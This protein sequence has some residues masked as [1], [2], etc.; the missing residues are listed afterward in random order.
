MKISNTILKGNLKITEN[1]NISR[2][3]LVQEDLKE[4]DPEQTRSEFDLPK[5]L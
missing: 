3:S 1:T 5:I 2:Y 4:A